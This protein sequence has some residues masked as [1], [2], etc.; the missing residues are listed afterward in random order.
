[1]SMDSLHDLFVN[2]LKDIHSAE[3]QITKALPRLA[4][5]A[6][7]PELRKA[8]EKHLAQ[9]EVQIERLDRIDA[10]DPT[11]PARFELIA[12][13]AGVYPIRLI[14]ADRRIGRLD[15]RP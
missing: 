7:S 13:D 15:I 1:M 9:T 4:K 11:T 8:F 5:A 6:Q 12:E 10:I 3:R 14:E 2:E